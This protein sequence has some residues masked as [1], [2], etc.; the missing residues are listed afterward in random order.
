MSGGRNKYEDLTKARLFEMIA[1]FDEAGV[2][3]V[4]L[5]GGEPQMSPYLWDVVDELLR[6]DMYVSH[7]HT[8]AML[9]DGDFFA[10]MKKR[11]LS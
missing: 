9:L 10:E 3:E 1:Q 6:R 2:M 8:N 5:S 7:F 4:E 11:N